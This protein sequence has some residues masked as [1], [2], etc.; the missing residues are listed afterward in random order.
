M[1]IALLSKKPQHKITA[2]TFI[3]CPWVSTA[4]CS[5]TLIAWVCKWIKLSIRPSSYKLITCRYM[6]RSLI[7]FG[8]QTSNQHTFLS[9]TFS[10]LQYFMLD[11]NCVHYTQ[12]K[13]QWQKNSFH[14]GPHFCTFFVRKKYMF[15]SPCISTCMHNVIHVD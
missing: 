13:V 12:F 15:Y 6:P 4:D 7:F 8:M 3:G 11:A 2:K 5:G 14:L 10:V 1:S 9:L